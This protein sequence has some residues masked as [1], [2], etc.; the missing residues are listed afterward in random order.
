MAMAGLAKG[1]GQAPK[2]G[3]GAVV[4]GPVVRVARGNDVTVV[5][6]GAR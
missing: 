1:M 6:A 5:S 2:S 3:A 4:T